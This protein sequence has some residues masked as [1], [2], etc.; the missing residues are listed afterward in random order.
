MSVNLPVDPAN[1]FHQL[2]DFTALIGLV[3]AIDRVLHA[4]SYVIP[5]DFLLDAAKC[6]PHSGNLGDDVDAIPILVDHLRESTN[7][8]FDPV[9]PFFAGN[10]D[11][12]SHG[13]Y[14]PPEGTSG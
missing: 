7:L 6:R 11:V 4:V 13:P 10:L 1:D 12:V 2:G 14:I 5:Q 3:A 9:Q 8:A